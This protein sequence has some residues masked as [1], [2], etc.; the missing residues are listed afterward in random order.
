[1]TLISCHCS[2]CDC[3]T[4]SRRIGLEIVAILPEHRNFLPTSIYEKSCRE[5]LST[6]KSFFFLLL[7]AA[8]IQHHRLDDSFFLSPCLFVSSEFWYWRR[9]SFF[10]KKPSGLSLAAIYLSLTLMAFML[11]VLLMMMMMMMMMMIVLTVS[12]ESVLCLSPFKV[13]ILLL[14]ISDSWHLLQSIHDRLIDR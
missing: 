1:M 13:E 7:Q 3:C 6:E 12:S 9:I 4:F 2:T 14:H 5:N 11:D 8:S 10:C